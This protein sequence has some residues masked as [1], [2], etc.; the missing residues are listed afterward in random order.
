[1]I[2]LETKRAATKWTG[3]NQG[4]QEHRA[5]CMKHNMAHMAESRDKVYRALA[6]HK[7]FPLNFPATAAAAPGKQLCF[8]VSK[9]VFKSQNTGYLQ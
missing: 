3:S 7:T 6:G 2:D 4:S 8:W 9:A 5:Q 1:M